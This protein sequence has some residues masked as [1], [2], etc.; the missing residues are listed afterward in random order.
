M[1]F[2]SCIPTIPYTFSAF[3]AVDVRPAGYRRERLEDKHG[4]QRT[5][6][7]QPPGHHQLLEGKSS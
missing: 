7:P 1:F 3:P 5:V 6:Q 2:V 4:I